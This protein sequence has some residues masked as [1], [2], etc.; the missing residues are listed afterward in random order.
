MGLF[1]KTSRRRSQVRKNIPI[2]RFSRINRL[3]NRDSLISI[4]ICAA[5]IAVC[6][7]IISFEINGQPPRRPLAPTTVLVMLISVAA[8][9]YIHD[10][11]KRLI[12]NHA[13]TSL[14]AGLV[15][16]LLT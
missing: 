11:Q 4:L 7:P 10:Y 3:A 13:R 15:L 8:L 9:L 16:L 6:V 5:F 14:L 1:G 2:D 12:R